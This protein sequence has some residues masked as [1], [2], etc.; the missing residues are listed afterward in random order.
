L[1][2]ASWNDLAESERKTQRCGLAEKLAADVAV[3]SN[4]IHSQWTEG[5]SPFRTEFLNED[6]QGENFQLITDGIFYLE[7][8]TKSQKL[9]IPL[10]LD[11]KCSSVTCP[12]LV[13]SPYSETSLRNVRT[14]AAEFLRIFNGGSGLGFD[15]LINQEGFTD[16]TLRFQNQLSDVDD[17]FA[18]IS[19]SLNDQL[20][21]VEADA[22]DPACLNAFANP[23][24]ESIIDACSLAGLLKRVT[25]DLKIEF[26]TIVGVAIPGRVQSDND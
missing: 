7:T 1:A 17:K 20:A 19:G 6:S 25:D 21:L 3:A 10:G 2:T 13:E 23:S 22:S 12:G 8:F 18:Q 26:V 9:T 5:D 15:D 24:D 11:D 4:L 16:I 14:N